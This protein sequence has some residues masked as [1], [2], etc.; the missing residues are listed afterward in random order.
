MKGTDDF[1]A[2]FPID[3]DDESSAVGYS[4]CPGRKPF[5]KRLCHITDTDVGDKL[6]VVKEQADRPDDDLES[7]GNDEKHEQDDDND[8][9]DSEATPP[10][11]LVLERQYASVYAKNESHRIFLQRQRPSPSSSKAFPPAALKPP[12]K[13]LARQQ[14]ERFFN[15]P[16]SVIHNAGINPL[17]QTLHTSPIKQYR[18]T[19]CVL[20]PQAPGGTK[21]SSYS[22]L[23]K[24]GKKRNVLHGNMNKIDETESAPRLSR[25]EKMHAFGHT[26]AARLSL[27]EDPVSPPEISTYHYSSVAKG[28]TNPSRTAAA[29][30]PRAARR[31]ALVLAEGTAVSSR[32]SYERVLKKE[33]SD[34]SSLSS[35]KNDSARS[36]PSGQHD[37]H[38][39]TKKA[40]NSSS[41][42]TTATATATATTA[43]KGG[44]AKTKRLYRGRETFQMEVAQCRGSKNDNRRYYPEQI[45]TNRGLPPQFASRRP[46]H[47]PNHDPSS[48]GVLPNL[49]RPPKSTV[50]PTVQDIYNVLVIPQRGRG[51]S[52]L[53]T[54]STRP[55]SHQAEKSVGDIVLPP[56]QQQG[57]TANLKKPPPG[58]SAADRSLKAA[59]AGHS[60][61]MG[62][63][64][65]T[66][67]AGQQES[68]CRQDR[69]GNFWCNT[70]GGAWAPMLPSSPPALGYG[71]NG[72]FRTSAMN[73][74]QQQQ[75]TNQ[76]WQ[77]A[78]SGWNHQLATAQYPAKQG[79]LFEN[80]Y[81]A[82][83]GYRSHV[84]PNSFGSAPGQQNGFPGNW[85][86][87]DSFQPTF[88]QGLTGAAYP[89]NNGYWNTNMGPGGSHFGSQS[90]PGPARCGQESHIGVGSGS[91]G[92]ERH[93]FKPAPS[94]GD[95]CFS[96]LSSPREFQQAPPMGHQKAPRRVSDF[97]SRAPTPLS[98]TW[99][100]WL[101][102]EWHEETDEESK[103]A[104]GTCSK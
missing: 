57:P 31:N 69:L 35:V 44:S 55:T 15:S 87:A 102:T 20:S 98:G 30:P 48:S 22:P 1:L 38:V 10:P 2:M 19:E 92:D 79:Q 76:A 39:E 95:I 60:S 5:K 70:N 3:D 16:D 63:K 80:Y 84:T 50:Q 75:Q 7:R 61:T 77:Q 52:T 81:Q 21:S 12:S 86:D 8:D 46:N 64:A 90:V 89:A 17:V 58:S 47:R 101:L 68:Y 29:K 104:I 41:T 49:L 40:T 4:S 100:W 25:A 62:T 54:K 11:L 26:K 59:P 13:E 66:A 6:S 36:L 37:K 42:A 34:R 88:Q 18:K 32:T 78:P 67:A 74:A 27:L 73:V 51:S 24:S 91:P 85:C 82:E 97:T 83:F 65:M 43:G 23:N 94:I 14:G 99:W 93:T 71:Q 53:S 9:D 33:D 72:N 96:P 45:A 103:E 56:L 28:A